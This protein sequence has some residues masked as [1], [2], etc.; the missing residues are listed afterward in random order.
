MCVCQLHPKF[1]LQCIHLM[2]GC[3]K[4]D[5]DKMFNACHPMMYINKSVFSYGDWIFRLIRCVV[6]SITM[7]FDLC[8]AVAVNLNLG[9]L[10]FFF[11]KS[12]TL[13]CQFGLY[14][15]V[16]CTNA[17]Q[18]SFQLIYDKYTTGRW[19]CAWEWDWLYNLSVKIWKR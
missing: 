8:L 18:A 9:F 6:A 2:L 13:H 14:V 7:C 10:C 1:S 3:V 19:S 4:N 17:K 11:F 16:M 15:N 5:S 12:I